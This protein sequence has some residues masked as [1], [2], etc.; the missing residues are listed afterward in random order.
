MNLEI[1]IQ[2]IVVS[3][4]Y[5]MFSSFVYNIFYFILNCKSKIF[6]FFFNFIYSITIFTTY[7]IILFIIN[8]GIIHIYFVSLFILGF[9]SGNNKLKKIR[10]ELK[11]S[12]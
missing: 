1:Q 9:L 11:K 8:Y 12:D 3:L 4:I 10:I 7:Y 6:K 2:S 5:G